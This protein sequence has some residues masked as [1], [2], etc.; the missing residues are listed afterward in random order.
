MMKIDI[1][2]LRYISDCRPPYFR[3]V[4]LLRA[5]HI[6][7]QV[8]EF[9]AP[10]FSVLLDQVIQAVESIKKSIPDSKAELVIPSFRVSDLFDDTLPEDLQPPQ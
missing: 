9:N 7:Q 2:V 3:G 4:I 6:P 8:T 5:E 1:R 10:T